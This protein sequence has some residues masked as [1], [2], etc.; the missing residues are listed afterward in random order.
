MFRYVIAAF[1]LFLC[2]APAHAL[3]VENASG[4]VLYCSVYREGYAMPL[5]QFVLLPGKTHTWSPPLPAN[6]ALV[7]RAMAERRLT[8]KIEPAT[9]AL[10]NHR[11]TVVAATDKD[12]LVLGVHAPQPVR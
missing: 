3:T 12:A 8:R 1:L 4:A 9:C 11:A 6:V 10:R 7:V 5:T 2:S